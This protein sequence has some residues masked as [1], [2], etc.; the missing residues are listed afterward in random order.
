MKQYNSYFFGR[1][2]IIFGRQSIL[3]AAEELNAADKENVLIV[4]D[5]FISKSGMLDTLLVKMKEHNISYSI[6]DRVE[7]DPDAEIVKKALN[8][9]KENK[10]DS[11]IGIG[12][13]SS[14][15]TAKGVRLMATN[16]GS[17]F[18]YSNGSNGGKK[19]KNHGLFLICIPTT[20]GT[21]SEVTPYAII[22]NHEE[23]QKATIS[24]PE[25][26]PDIAV[27]DPELTLGLPAS[28]TASTGMDALAHAIGGYTSNRVIGAPG[29]TTLSDTIA[30]TAIKL[31][32]QNLRT[33]T[34][35]GSVYQARS[36]MMVASMMGAMASNAGG[37]AVHG[38]GHALGAMY[39]VPHGEACAIVMP[40]VLEHN[41]STCPERFVEIAKAFGIKTE[42]MNLMDAAKS[43]I[44]AIR[45]LQKDIG[46]PPLSK[47]VHSVE[48]EKF[49]EL[50]Q[51]AFIEKCSMLNPRPLTV[52][53]IKNIF[54]KAYNQE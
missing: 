8:C 25:N 2:K 36:N 37:D 41:Y 15:D 11:V 31:I 21:G 16:E 48:D 22:T 20:A 44:D 23:N 17:I 18:D 30:I 52:E 4:T 24:T 5:Q 29:D 1:T 14:M 50:C 19:V 12:G 26:L 33:A 9:L 51:Q 45:E 53:A 6:F 35:C 42:N 54:V 34:H 43:S 27:I 38:L 7:S 39:H 40:Y 46:I 49:E 3:A 13:G 32:A 28:L 10:C 47:Y